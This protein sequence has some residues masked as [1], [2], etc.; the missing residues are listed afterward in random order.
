VCH[1][2][3]AVRYT[4]GVLNLTGNAVDLELLDPAA[5]ATKDH[6]YLARR[7]DNILIARA[8]ANTM[9]AWLKGELM[10]SSALCAC[11]PKHQQGWHFLSLTASFR[12]PKLQLAL[13]NGYLHQPTLS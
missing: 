10:I 5:E 11:Q 9:H 1:D 2:D 12:M 6:A 7:G 4:V 13:I 8:N 3:E